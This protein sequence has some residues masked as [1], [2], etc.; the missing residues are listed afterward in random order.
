[1]KRERR[2]THVVDLTREEIDEA[3]IEFSSRRADLPQGKASVAIH[4][5]DALGEVLSATIEVYEVN[6]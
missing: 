5:D 6:K 3:L 4:V 1:M 2:V